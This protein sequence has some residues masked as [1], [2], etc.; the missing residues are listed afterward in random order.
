M[1]C[2]SS[3]RLSLW[4]LLTPPLLV[5]LLRCASLL[6]DSYVISEGRVVTFLLFTLG[7][8]VPLQLNW[9]GLLLPSPPPDTQKP[10]GLLPPSLPLS[11]VRRESTTLLVSVG[12]LV[13]C[14]YLSLYFHS[15]RE[16]QGSCQPSVF[17]TPLSRVLDS[18]MRNLHY[19]LSLAS[20]SA[21]AF[22]LYRWLRHY[23]NL[24]CTSVAVFTARFLLPLTSISMGLHWAVSSTP[25]DSFRNLA[26]LI[27]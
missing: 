19:I 14:L 9:E 15:C 6:S 4:H 13:G 27:R 17:L 20:L 11:T 22:L 18:R 5:L 10:P 24:N 23:G 8:Y 25:E 12:V 1:F 3:G 26:E 2:S 7:L 21:W 16:E